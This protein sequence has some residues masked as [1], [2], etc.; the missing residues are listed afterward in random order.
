MKEFLQGLYKRNPVFFLM[1]GLC[2]TLAVTT[3][4]SNAIAMSVATIF[5]LVCS[6]IIISL[7]RKL[8]PD[9]IRIP[10]FIVII[11]TFVTM[12]YLFMQAYTPEMAESLGIYLMLIVVNC[13]VLGRAL[14]FAYKN[15][16]WLTLQ[17]SMGMGL[18]FTLALIIISAIREFIGTGSILGYE[19]FSSGIMIFVFPPGAL[20]VMGLIL[21]FKQW[22]TSDE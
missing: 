21:G 18:G 19:I 6:G 1:L 16:I 3:T 5:V 11:A 7:T 22:R 8:I 20:L 13:I 10:S 17:D 15:P 9:E 14:A 4:V 12:V 2:P